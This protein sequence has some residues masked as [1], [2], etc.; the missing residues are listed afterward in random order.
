MRNT[1]KHVNEK[2]QIITLGKRE[3]V[4]LCCRLGSYQ[5]TFTVLK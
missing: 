5:I 1:T 4:E 3:D 2:T